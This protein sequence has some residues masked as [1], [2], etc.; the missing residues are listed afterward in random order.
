MSNK[1][2][3]GLSANPA[4]SEP[5]TPETVRARFDQSIGAGVTFIYF[6]P[7]WSELEPSPG[8]YNFSELDAHLARARSASI[9]LCLNLRV[10]DTN[11]RSMPAD[12]QALDFT[13]PNVIERLTVLITAIAPRLE[14]DVWWVMI[15]NEVS[16]Y[17]ESRQSEIDAYRVLFY[18]AAYRFKELI[19]GIQTSVNITYDGLTHAQGFLKPLLDSC[20]FLSLN[21]YPLKPD[22]TYRNP[23][24]VGVEIGRMVAAAKG[25]KALLQEVG[26]SSSELNGSSQIKQSNFVRNVLAALK[27]RPASF[28]GA[29][30]FLMSDLS[31]TLVEQ[32]AQYYSLPDVARFKAYLKTLGMFDDQGQPKLSWQTFQ[33]NSRM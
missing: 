10:I 27:A 19:P 25:K 32:F 9:P 14:D 12:L 31:D 3:I 30:F 5:Y 8:Q 13:D 6:A 29:N 18:F 21:Y 28:L 1:P 23:S 20:D 11:Q 22:F 15:G 24:V 33:R 16:S 26:Y 2:L 17:F 7:K 4:A